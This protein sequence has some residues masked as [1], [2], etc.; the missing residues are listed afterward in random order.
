M[1]FW[2]GVTNYDW[3]R[4]HA[5]RASPEV[6]FWQPSLRPAFTRAPNGMLFLFKLKS[7]H[8]AIAG[9]GRWVS[10]QPFPVSVAWELFGEA[11]G[12][13]DP[14]TFARLITGRSD[15]AAMQQLVTCQMLTE[16]FYLPKSAWV[17][18]PASFARN[19]VVGKGYDDVAADGQALLSAV[20]AARDQAALWEPGVTFDPENKWGTPIL[21]RPR[22]HQGGFRAQLFDAYGRRCA[23]TGE[24][25]LPALDAA[26]I[27]PFA[28]ASGTHEVSNGLL[29]RADFHRLFDNGLVTVEPTA[30]ADDAA[31]RIRVSPRISE[32]W[33]N[34]KAYYRL[35]GQPLAT[36]PERAEWRPDPDKLR[37][38]NREVFQAA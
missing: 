35:D 16:V 33:F 11:N 21:T 9:G 24:N 29:L 34:G 25:T 36:V 10:T 12:A 8:D 7:P 17:K 20:W 37:W 23:L 38:H 27:V 14:F 26:H 2:V 15:R 18:Q 3:Y 28:N 4:F 31:Y 30:S 1:K 6:N 22:L 13:D 19:I 5:G 32:L